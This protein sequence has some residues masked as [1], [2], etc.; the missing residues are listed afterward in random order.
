MVLIDDQDGRNRARAEQVWLQRT[1]APGTLVLWSTRQVLK[2]ITLGDGEAVASADV[3]LTVPSSFGD[4]EDRRDQDGDSEDDKRDIRRAAV[5]VLHGEETKGPY[6]WCG[7]TGGASSL[8]Y[9]AAGAGGVRTG[10]AHSGSVASSRSGAANI[11]LSHSASLV[12]RLPFQE[13]R[14]PTVCMVGQP[15]QEPRLVERPR[16]S[17]PSSSSGSD[18]LTLRHVPPGIPQ[19]LSEVACDL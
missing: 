3:T 4:R 16:R 2:Q 5:P 1:C 8:R 19:T 15:G 13:A 9:G 14:S 11:S 7:G 17:A 6:S 18:I 10:R 12:I